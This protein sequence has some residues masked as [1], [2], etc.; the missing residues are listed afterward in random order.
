MLIETT[1]G[2]LRLALDKVKPAIRFGRSSIPILGCVLLADGGVTATDLDHEIMVKFAAMRFDGR[3]AIP[4]RP[5]SRLVR[6]LP[7]D[8][9]IR[10]QDTERAKGRKSTDYGVYVT[11]TGGRYWLPSMPAEDFPEITPAGT[12]IKCKAPEN[13]L[14]A[15]DAC[16]PFISTEETRY[17]LNGVCFTKHPDGRDVVVATDGHRMIAHDLAHGIKGDLI[18]PRFV[19]TSLLGLPTPTQIYRTDTRLEL[20][21]PGAR[22][23]T[24]LIDA[25]YPDWPRVIPEIPDEAPEIRF[26]PRKMRAVL[27]RMEIGLSK[28][29]E[30]VDVCADPTGQTVVITAKTQDAEECSERLDGA[31]AVNWSKMSHGLASFNSRYLKE[32]CRTHIQSD[33]IILTAAGSGSP[34]RIGPQTG[35]MLTVLMPMRG[36]NGLG[37]QALMALSPA[38]NDP[39]TDQKEVA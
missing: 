11:F 14:Q 8:T 2:E 24:K 22:L 19:I 28:Y 6:A 27:N 36:G 10:L 1:A 15:L 25:T 3:V 23:R 9:D 21:M 4:F 35:K 12:W 33:E 17:Y 29:G 38:S 5:L 39:A 7:A 18:L 30:C 13:F 37:T 26:N 20:H 31:T 16:Q 32:I 34:S